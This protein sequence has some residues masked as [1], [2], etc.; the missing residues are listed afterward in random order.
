VAGPAPR[1]SSPAFQAQQTVKQ[2]GPEGGTC[3]ANDERCRVRLAAV[4]FPV[5]GAMDVHFAGRISAE[6]KAKVAPDAI[7][8]ERGFRSWQRSTNRKVLA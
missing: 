3:R 8:G 5:I 6:F 7:R 1:K 2:Q 4:Q